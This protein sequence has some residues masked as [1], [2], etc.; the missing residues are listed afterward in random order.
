VKL[1]IKVKIA[2][3]FLEKERFLSAIY[4]VYPTKIKENK[5]NNH[6]R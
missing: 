4:G 3:F 2:L 1:S 5:K 6:E